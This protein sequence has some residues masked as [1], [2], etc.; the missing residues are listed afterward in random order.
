MDQLPAL[1]ADDVVH[2]WA[3]AIIVLLYSC[4][5]AGWSMAIGH[6]CCCS[7][8][9]PG[10]TVKVRVPRLGRRLRALVGD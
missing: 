10:Q 4:P 6:A 5:P 1:F 8:D 7:P 3:G 2:L 9:T